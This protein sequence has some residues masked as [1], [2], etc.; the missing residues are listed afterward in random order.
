MYTIQYTRECVLL[1]LVSV[2]DFVV[3]VFVVLLLDCLCVEISTIRW[4]VAVGPKHFGILI[5]TYYIPVNR[6]Y[7]RFFLLRAAAN[8]DTRDVSSANTPC[9]KYTIYIPKYNTLN[10]Q[11]K[12]S[13]HT[14]HSPLQASNSSN[15]IKS[16]ADN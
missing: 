12:R 4:R 10:I 5:K 15:S 8:M 3:C 13:T 2:W 16:A 14:E 11:K 6:Q 9:S 7:S 1:L